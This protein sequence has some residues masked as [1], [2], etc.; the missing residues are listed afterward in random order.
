ML[1]EG[2]L[3]NPTVKYH[4]AM[5]SKGEDQQGLRWGR[6]LRQGLCEEEGGCM[7]IYQTRALYQ[8]YHD[9]TR[10]MEGDVI[11]PPS[12]VYWM[13]CNLHATMIGNRSIRSDGKGRLEH[14]PTLQIG[15]RLIVVWL[16]NIIRPVVPIAVQTVRRRW[17]YRKSE[18]VACCS[19]RTRWERRI[20]AGE[21]PEVADVID[22][23]DKHQK[24]LGEVSGL[25]EAIQ[26]ALLGV[27]S[28]MRQTRRTW[29]GRGGMERG[30]LAQEDEK[31]D[32]RA[33]GILGCDV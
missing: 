29:L 17:H 7:M 16:G 2:S 18:R 11:K 13:E 31:K 25:R 23:L 1:T 15:D 9:D 6:N 32:L 20:K 22:K 27:I 12:T 10:C 19:S 26:Q 5:R 4:A 28:L 33:C 24:I 21:Q 8:Q 30:S 3:R 14:E